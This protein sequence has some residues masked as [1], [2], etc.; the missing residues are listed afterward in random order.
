MFHKNKAMACRVDYTAQHSYDYLLYLS[1]M[2]G[3]QL[4]PTTGVVTSQPTVG[5]HI[6]GTEMGMII[7]LWALQMSCCINMV[8]LHVTA[9]QYS[10]FYYST[11]TCHLR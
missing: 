11:A 8:D 5:P 1:K 4:T 9:M 2:D 7:V 6:I 3:N 10:L